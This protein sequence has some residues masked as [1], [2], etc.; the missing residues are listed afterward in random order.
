M[1]AHSTVDST[2]G[3]MQ[4]IKVRSWKRRRHSKRRERGNARDG[5]RQR[6]RRPTPDAGERSSSVSL[7]RMR[8][9]SSLLRRAESA[10][11]HMPPSQRANESRSQP[12][13]WNTASSSTTATTAVFSAIVDEALI[14]LSVLRHPR[15]SLDEWQRAEETGDSA[16]RRTYPLCE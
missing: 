1:T 6:R 3:E 2:S 13:N 8:I 5:R 11:V 9:H 14:R 16:S 10:R 7:S 15:A 12:A 4:R